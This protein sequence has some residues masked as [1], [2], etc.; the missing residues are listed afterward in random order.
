MP[1]IGLI[2]EVRALPG[3]EEFTADTGEWGTFAWN[4]HLLGA[5]RLPHRW[6]LG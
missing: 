6:R 5:P 1:H 2:N 4:A 3:V